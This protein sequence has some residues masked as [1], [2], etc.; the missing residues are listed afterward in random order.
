MSH[1]ES[2]VTPNAIFRLMA[3]QATRNRGRLLD[4]DSIRLLCAER[5]QFPI[6]NATLIGNITLNGSQFH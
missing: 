3:S 6:P 1:I 2:G 4:G 5:L